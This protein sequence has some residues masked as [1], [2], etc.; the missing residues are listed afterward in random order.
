MATTIRYYTLLHLAKAPRFISSMILPP[1]CNIH[2]SSAAKYYN[3]DD[4]S[5]DEDD[6][7]N[8]DVWDAIS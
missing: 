5:D 6:D 8:D 2:F 7:E 3:D 1:E 4:G